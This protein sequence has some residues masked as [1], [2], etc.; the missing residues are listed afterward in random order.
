MKNI[1][2]ISALIPTLYSCV[3]N[4]SNEYKV[5][6]T[7]VCECME[8]RK[9]IQRKG[10]SEEVAFIYDDE[11]YKICILDA[12]INQIDTKSKDFTNAIE[13]I[14]PQNLEVQKRYLKQI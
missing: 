14:C 3:Q 10:I 13:D 2:L 4:Y 9:S 12:I 8:Y 6:A 11:D 1:L 5:E 7:K